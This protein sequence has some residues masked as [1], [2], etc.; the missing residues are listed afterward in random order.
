MARTNQPHG[1]SH[2]YKLSAVISDLI[3]NIITQSA[4]RDIFSTTMK[5]S[6]VFT[7]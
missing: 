5:F 6:W 7:G 4:E 3:N 1:Q 2:Y